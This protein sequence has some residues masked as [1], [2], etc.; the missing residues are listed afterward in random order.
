MADFSS[1]SNYKLLISEAIEMKK[2]KL[3]PNHVLNSS[4]SLFRFGHCFNDL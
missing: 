1:H 3:I 4:L 2:Y